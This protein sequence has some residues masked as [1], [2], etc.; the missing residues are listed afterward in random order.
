MGYL[1]NSTSMT[2]L[3]KTKRSDLRAALEENGAAIRFNRHPH[4]GSPGAKAGGQSGN[5]GRRCQQDWQTDRH[6]I[7]RRGCLR[8]NRRP[9]ERWPCRNSCSPDKQTEQPTARS[10]YHCTG[11]SDNVHRP[12]VSTTAQATDSL[13]GQHPQPSQTNYRR[14]ALL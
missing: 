1:V 10:T 8:C 14:V 3:N 12:I 4:S 11:S 2:E 9:N 6:Y 5:C 7:R 13:S